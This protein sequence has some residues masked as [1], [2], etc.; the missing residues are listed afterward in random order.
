[1]GRMPK[2]KHAYFSGLISARRGRG[3]ITPQ[4][5]F[6]L[7]RLRFMPQIAHMLKADTRDVYRNLL[8]L[9]DLNPTQNARYSQ[10]LGKI[11]PYS[12]TLYHWGQ[13]LS[14][15]LR[16]LTWIPWSYLNHDARASLTNLTGYLDLLLQKFHSDREDSAVPLH[17]DVEALLQDSFLKSQ[18]ISNNIH[19]MRLFTLQRR[20]ETQTHV[21]AHV[22]AHALWSALAL[23]RRFERV[24]LLPR[25]LPQMPSIV[26]SP[27]LILHLLYEVSFEFRPD[28]AE[29]PQGH[30]VLFLRQ[31]DE[32]AEFCVTMHEYRL[33]PEIWNR[34]WQGKRYELLREL[35]GSIEPLTWDE[36]DGQG[37]IVRLPWAKP[38]QSR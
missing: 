8:A 18:R 19:N 37:V 6:R 14:G 35:G 20:E 34:W 38:S 26:Y 30:E 3:T 22:I 24:T 11:I 23:N 2:D 10:I 7:Q 1:M 12:T 5:Q 28:N 21:P 32:G 36:G 27:A 17:P 9:R 16:I 13:T 25:P 4:V 33:L 15:N 31:A 29:T